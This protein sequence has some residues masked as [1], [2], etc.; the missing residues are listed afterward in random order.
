MEGGELLEVNHTR[1]KT[2]INHERNLNGDMVA[3]S[4]LESFF[5]SES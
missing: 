3:F 4:S 1:D 2:M 5:D